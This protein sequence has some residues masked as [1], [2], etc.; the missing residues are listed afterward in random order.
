MIPIRG[1]SLVKG[2]KKKKIVALVVLYHKSQVLLTSVHIVI[3]RE[4][5]RPR[6]KTTSVGFDV[7]SGARNI[8]Y[9]LVTTATTTIDFRHVVVHFVTARKLQV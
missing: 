9:R 2:K 6:L 4:V 7:R 5:N 8:C 3:I 1:L